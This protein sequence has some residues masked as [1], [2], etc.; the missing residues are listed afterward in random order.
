MEF[1]QRG[2]STRWPDSY[3]ANRV[4]EIERELEQLEAKR[5]RVL[6][7]AVQANF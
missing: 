6:D 5:R 1:S 3:K 2:T 7:R 4:V